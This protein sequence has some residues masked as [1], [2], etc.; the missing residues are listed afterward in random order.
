[1]SSTPLNLGGPNNPVIVTGDF[2]K[3]VNL[4]TNATVSGGFCGPLPGGHYIVSV[5][6]TGWNGAT[7]TITGLEDD[8]VTD[9]P[10]LQ[11]TAN[12]A[13]EIEIGEGGQLKGV[14]SAAVPTHGIYCNISRV[15]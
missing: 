3:P 2:G 5:S 12:G 10:G 6:S 15:Q 1:M 8:G 4:L 14:I 9:F 11:L 13:A 7:L